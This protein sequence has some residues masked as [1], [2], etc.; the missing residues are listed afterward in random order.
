MRRALARELAGDAPERPELDRDAANDSTPCASVGRT[1]ED[2]LRALRAARA[3][4]ARLANA[5]AQ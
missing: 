4:R 3:R 1:P 5:R 2:R